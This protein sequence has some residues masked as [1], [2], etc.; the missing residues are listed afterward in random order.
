MEV[1]IASKETLPRPSEHLL[2][3]ARCA[4]M[5]HIS[6]TF[7]GHMYR[8][9]VHVQHTC[10]TVPGHG[11]ISMKTAVHVSLSFFLSFI[12]LFTQ[13]CVG[14]PVHA[15]GSAWRCLNAPVP[16]ETSAQR[17]GSNSSQENRNRL[18]T[19][20]MCPLVGG[21][22]TAP[23]TLP[24]RCRALTRCRRCCCSWRAGACCC[25]TERVRARLAVG[26]ATTAVLLCATP[27]QRLRARRRFSAPAPPDRTTQ[28][29][30]GPT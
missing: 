7:T 3:Q 25:S 1:V 19:P 30:R 13:L 11:G 18:A 15:W 14:E 6:G 4:C 17:S 28:Q 16:P 26:P 27:W 10:K 20:Q 21:L 24:A 29:V 9:H 5:G 2:L 23:L 12:F 8:A 22:S